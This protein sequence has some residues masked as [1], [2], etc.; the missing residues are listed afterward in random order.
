[1]KRILIVLGL[2][3]LINSPVLAVESRDYHNPVT[4]FNYAP[5]DIQYQIGGKPSFFYTVKKGGTDVYSAGVLD[6]RVLITIAACTDKNKDGFCSTIV[7]HM[8][9]QYYNANLIKSIQIKS[10]YDYRVICLDNGVTTC[11]QK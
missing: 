3:A 6:N 4:V 8:N 9:P 10:V 1:M 7:S 11:L 5:Y 2:T